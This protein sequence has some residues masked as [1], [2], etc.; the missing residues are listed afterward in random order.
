MSRR[1]RNSPIAL[2]GSPAALSLARPA[3]DLRSH[4]SLD[5]PAQGSRPLCMPFSVG[6]AHEAARALATGDAPSSLAVES[7]WRHCVQ[8]GVA[9]PNGTTLPDVSSALART[10]QPVASTWPYDPTL[11]AGTEQPPAAAGPAPWLTAQL[12]LVAL[13]HDSIEAEIEDTLISKHPVLLVVEATDEFTFPN[14]GVISLP[15][16][17]APS[18]EYHA[19]LAVGAATDRKRRVRH[20]LIRN[21]WGPY[22]G[23]G[24]YGWLPMGYLINFAVQAAAVQSLT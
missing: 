15:Q 4:L 12:G 9:G 13:R 14:H 2:P 24:G 11:G 5:V 22:W 10:G 8:A 1:T 17:T 3:V 6:G 21:S 20:L 23:A 16:L 7:L 19:V 18:S